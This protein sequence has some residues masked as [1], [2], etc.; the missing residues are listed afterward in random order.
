MSASKVL[1]KWSNLTRSE[2]NSSSARQYA[3]TAGL[4][5]ILEVRTQAWLE[6]HGVPFKYEGEKWGYQYKPQK[7]TPDFIV[8]GPTL[9]CKGKLT[10]DV[11]K[12]LVAIKE[13][14]PNEKIALIFEKPDNKINRGSKTTYAAWAEQNGFLWSD[15]VPRAEWFK[16]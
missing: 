3:K 7:Y 2:Q 8:N 14:N 6:E 16:K 4:K 15:V 12:K 10:K 9:E 11:R 5:S 1:E 13:C